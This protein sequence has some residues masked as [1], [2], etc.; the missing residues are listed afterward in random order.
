MQKLTFE[1]KW[2]KT[3][4]DQDRERIKQLFQKT[5]LD[6]GINIQFTSLWQA[7]NHR[8]ELL[9]AVLIHNT[10][11]RNF[12]FLDQ[13]MTYVVSGTIFAEHTFPSPITV[14]K[15]T[16]MPWTFIFPVGS[17]NSSQSF[18]DGVLRI[19]S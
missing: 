12:T 10:S 8:G 16:S 15:Q 7:K 19:T 18:E 11:Q 5:I 6:P 3:I 14:E 9:V 13:I 2:D 1:S 17:F 4:A